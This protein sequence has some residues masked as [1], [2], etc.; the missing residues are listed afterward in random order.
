M[1]SYKIASLGH[2]HVHVCLISAITKIVAINAHALCKV[3]LLHS[4]RHNKPIWQGWKLPCTFM[5]KQIYTNKAR[6]IAQ[7][8]CYVCC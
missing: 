4:D 6:T 8:A 1:Y 3:Q 7:M 5:K 2:L